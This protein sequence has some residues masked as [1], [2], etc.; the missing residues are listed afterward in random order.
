MGEVEHDGLVGT[1]GLVKRRQEC[2]VVMEF[3]PSLLHTVQRG[4][5]HTS[6]T[7]KLFTVQIHL[8]ISVL[9]IKKNTHGSK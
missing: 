2:Y 1:V 3:L 6:V 8:I 7:I 5:H 9:P 4:R